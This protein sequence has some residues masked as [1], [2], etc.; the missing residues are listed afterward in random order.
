MRLRGNKLDML[1]KVSPESRD[2]PRDESGAPLVDRFCLCDGISGFAL[3]I[4]WKAPEAQQTARELSRKLREA[5]REPC[6]AG[7]DPGAHHI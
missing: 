4:A 2:I 3:K 1:R 5:K 7:I 6:K